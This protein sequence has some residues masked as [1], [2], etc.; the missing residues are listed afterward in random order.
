MMT[1]EGSTKSVNFM[2]SWAGVL[3]LGPCHIS[4]IVKRHYFFKKYSS[5]V[6]G[7]IRQSKYI[8][9]MTNEEST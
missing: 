9:M 4:Y 7:K 3:V 8:V 1:K 6:L 5:L 2:T